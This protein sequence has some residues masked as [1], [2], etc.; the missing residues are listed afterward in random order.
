MKITKQYYKSIF[1]VCKNGKTVREI[2]DYLSVNRAT[3]ATHMSK[4][5]RAGILITHKEK[6]TKYNTP[7]IYTSSIC[8]TLDEVIE[9]WESNHGISAEASR[10]V[11]QQEKENE[12]NVQNYGLNGIC[13]IKDR[14][15][16]PPVHIYECWK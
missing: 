4:L 2:A 15:R 10:P 1:L 8:K 16:K 7:N 6:P 14:P 5:E 3:L 9:F 13:Y 11:N 12:G